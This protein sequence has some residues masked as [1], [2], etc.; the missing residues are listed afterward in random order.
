MTIE[1]EATHMVQTVV[2]LVMAE[3]KSN[4][5]SG[6]SNDLE[7]QSLSDLTELYKMYMTNFRFYKDNG[8]LSP[9]RE[10]QMMAQIDYIFSIIESRSNTKK[11][12]H[13]DSDNTTN[14]TVS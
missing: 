2:N 4:K 7:N 6:E 10:K 12:S 5:K 1:E 11:R 8:T 3:D 14:N 13:I 9:N